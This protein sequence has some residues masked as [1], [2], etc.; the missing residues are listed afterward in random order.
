MPGID[1][2]QKI[3]TDITLSIFYTFSLADLQDK[4]QFKDLK[5]KPL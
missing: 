5:R 3:G 1:R 4:F 2:S